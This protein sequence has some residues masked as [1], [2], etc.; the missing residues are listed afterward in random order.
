M[1]EGPELPSRGHSVAMQ[2]ARCAAVRSC[3]RRLAVSSLVI[4][5]LE[6]A[7]VQIPFVLGEGGP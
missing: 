2:S 5:D 1:A 4:I 7:R 6:E 3:F